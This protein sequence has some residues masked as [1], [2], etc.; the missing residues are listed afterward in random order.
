[1]DVTHRSAT[2]KLSSTLNI[3]KVVKEKDH[4][5]Y[6]HICIHYWEAG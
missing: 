6:L 3:G 1:M 4:I 5:L 2:A